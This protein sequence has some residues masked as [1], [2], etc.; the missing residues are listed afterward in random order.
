MGSRNFLLIGIF[1]LIAL[2]A[3]PVLPA[4]TQTKWEPPAACTQRIPEDFHPLTRTERLSLWVHGL[5][6]AHTIAFTAIRAGMNQALDSPEEWP[7]DARGFGYRAASAYGQSA[8]G[9]SFKEG[10]ALAF[11]EDNRYFASGEQGA[12]PRLKYAVSS[13]FL[14]RH[15]NGSRSVSVSA[16]SGPAIGAVISRSWQPTSTNSMADAARSYGISMAVSVGL[17]VG[18]EFLPL[19]VRRLLP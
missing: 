17:N 7:N 3:Q 10:F 14:A 16:L 5:T 8:I 13:T 4:Q 18:R 9:N 2:Q 12:W 6:G 1:S 15:D 19:F 11:D